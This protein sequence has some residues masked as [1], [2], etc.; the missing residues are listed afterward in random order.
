MFSGQ[1]MPRNT[2]KC[3][4]TP[5]PPLI[6]GTHPQA[7]THTKP[8]ASHDGSGDSGNVWVAAIP[9]SL[10]VPGISLYYTLPETNI[11]P[12]N[13]QT[14]KRKVVFQPSI[15]RGKLF[16]SGRVVGGG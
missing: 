10:G 9:P 8:G 6:S 4:S 5:Q 11:A 13:R 2:Q 16:V 1:V 14:P 3:D 7:W 12:E 15:F